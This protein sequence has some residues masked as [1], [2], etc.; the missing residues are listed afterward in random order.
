MK[1]GGG[2]SVA[3]KPMFA[4][5]M[6]PEHPRGYSLVELMIVV[7]IISIIAAIAIPGYREMVYSAQVVTAI[8]DIRQISNEVTLYRMTNRRYPTSLQD[9]GMDGKLD[10]WDRPYE[11]LLMTSEKGKK[12]FRKDKNLH[13][14][15]SDYDLYSCGRDGGS[16]PPPYRE[17]EPR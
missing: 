1:T 5:G 13:P 14:L 6:R 11:Y 8:A 9:V 16:V 10:P 12:G 15:N 4:G 17:T 7:A 2:G 3:G